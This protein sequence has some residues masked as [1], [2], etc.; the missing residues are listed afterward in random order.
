MDKKKTLESE[1]VKVNTNNINNKEKIN[2]NFF[3]EKNLQEING[4][5]NNENTKESNIKLFINLF[6][7]N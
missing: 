6:I 2:L 5:L 1:F 4:I 3:K 7:K